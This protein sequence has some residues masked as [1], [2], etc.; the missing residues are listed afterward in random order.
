MLACRRS[1]D[2]GST[3]TIQ[4]RLFAIKHLLQ[5]LPLRFVGLAG[6][7]GFEA[8]DVCSCDEFLHLPAP[9]SLPRDRCHAGPH[10]TRQQLH[11]GASLAESDSLGIY[12]FCK[13]G[14]G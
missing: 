11:S 3:D 1:G 12:L 5:K 14:D 2:A 10:I 7:K 4:R 8:R 13:S 6:D 9:P